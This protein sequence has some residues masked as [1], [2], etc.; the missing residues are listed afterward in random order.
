MDERFRMRVPTSFRELQ[1]YIAES[2]PSVK[3]EVPDQADIISDP[4]NMFFG[5]S[6][7]Q[8]STTI[9]KYPLIET[10]ETVALAD[11]KEVRQGRT[12]I[13]E[14]CLPKAFPSTADH[15]KKFFS[16]AG[17]GKEAALF[18]KNFVNTAFTEKRPYKSDSLTTAEKF[19]VRVEEQTGHM[20]RLSSVLTHTQGFLQ[21][22]FWAREKERAER[23]ENPDAELQPD[24]YP[25]DEVDA[26]IHLAGFCTAMIGRLSLKLKAEIGVD[27]RKRFFTAVDQAAEKAQKDKKVQVPAYAKSQLLEL[28][29][30]GIDLFDGQF[31]SVFQEG[32]KTQLAV[33]QSV[34]LAKTAISS[35]QATASTSAPNQG[36]KQA[37]QQSQKKA[38]PA[39]SAGSAAQ[40]A[41]DA[42][43]AT[44]GKKGQ[45][46][47]GGGN[48]RGGGSN[49]KGKKGTGGG[50]KSQKP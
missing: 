2:C 37:Q 27:R 16:P 22:A 26:A 35:S 28:P 39:S 50:G 1:K 40:T 14:A 6:T 8:S 31:G 25:P 3:A 7:K 19:A 5:V 43:P 36:K 9:P 45:G 41:K 12:S 38:T 48:Y 17:F 4:T 33:H 47:G 10:Y 44:T 29:L 32:T 49:Y 11:E 30:H 34:Q 23:L 13:G 46:G 42:S 24:K 21:G 15:E 18:T 20:A